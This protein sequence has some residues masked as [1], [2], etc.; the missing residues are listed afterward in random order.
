VAD[1]F[2]TAYGA[3]RWDLQIKA[4][5]TDA[6]N[7]VTRTLELDQVL[8][9]STPEEAQRIST[10]VIKAAVESLKIIGME[11]E[12]FRILE[13][14]PQLDENGLQKIQAEAFAKQLAKATREDGKARADAMRSVAEVTGSK[15]GQI[16]AELETRIKTAEAAGKGGIVLIGQGQGGMQTDPVQLA[17]LALLKKLSEG[18]ENK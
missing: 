2:K 10:A 7:A 4:I 12:G 6:I 13:I 9:A 18:G 5:I 1:P 8:T 14:N 16:A 15:E 11:I 17:Q 3:E